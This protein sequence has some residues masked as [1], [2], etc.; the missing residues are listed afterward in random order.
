MFDNVSVEVSRN[1]DV[2][3]GTTYLFQGV[4]PIMSDDKRNVGTHQNE[5]LLENFLRRSREVNVTRK[6]VAY[7]MLLSIWLLMIAWQTTEHLRVRESAATALVNRARDVSASLS[8]VMRSQGRFGIVR[9]ARLEA[10]LEELVH[11]TELWSVALLNASSDVALSAGKP[12]DLDLDDLVATQE[13]WSGDSATFVNLVALGPGTENSELSSQTPVIVQGPEPRGRGERPRPELLSGPPFRGMG[14][15]EEEREILRSM[16]NGTP[17]GDEQVDRILGLIPAELLTEPRE[18]T[19]RRA[20]LGRPLD[21]DTLADFMAIIYRPPIQ[22]DASS[23]RRPPWLGEADYQQLL[24]E[25]GVHWFV[26]TIPTGAMQHGLAQDLRLRAMVAGIAFLACLALVFSW[27]AFEKSSEFRIRLVR[28]EA[29]SIHLRELNMAAAGLVHE[30]KNPLNLI[31]GLAQIVT[32]EKTLPGATRDTALKITEEADRVTGRLNQFLDYSRPV[33]PCLKP[34]AL[35]GLVEE[36]LGVLD[37]DR[38]DKSVT[39]TRTG[40]KLT[41]EADEGMLRQLIFNLLLNALQSVSSG[42]KIDVQL[43]KEDGNACFEIRD[44]GPGVPAENRDEIFRPYFTTSQQ[45]TGLGLTVV[46]QIALAHQ[47][48][49]DCVPVKEGAVFRVSGIKTVEGAKCEPSR[50]EN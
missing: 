15:E 2:P 38:E 44:D 7:L 14:F 30:T 45:G 33:E 13:H 17:L 1:N 24:E 11:S 18:E 37:S 49:L 8:V 47:W 27:R 23:V 19:C 39:F 10:A 50:E 21:E 5:P 3:G 16:M 22:R 6:N 40:P 31:R 26:V 28:A 25:R 41:I 43:A 48:E 35:G 42:A 12:M 20:L 46:R 9:E 34:V 4:C 36:L 32:R 29:M